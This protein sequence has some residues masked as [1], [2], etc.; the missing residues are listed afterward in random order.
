MVSSLLVVSTNADGRECQQVFARSE[1]RHGPPWVS[2]AQK[3]AS[4]EK[5]T[6]EAW[7]EKKVVKEKKK[8]LNSA[9]WSETTLERHR[10]HGAREEKEGRAKKRTYLSAEPAA[11]ALCSAL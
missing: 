10:C 7:G 6:E 1:G 2:K 4:I 3:Q 8:I 5:L 11:G 9:T